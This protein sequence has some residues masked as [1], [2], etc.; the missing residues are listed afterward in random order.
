ME[1]ERRFRN[2]ALHSEEGARASLLYRL[3]EAHAYG[4]ME[5]EWQASLL[6]AV[7]ET[8]QASPFLSF[9]EPP[10][11]ALSP[12]RTTLSLRLTIDGQPVTLRLRVSNARVLFEEPGEYSLFQ[13]SQA[14]EDGVYDLFIQLPAL[15]TAGEVPNRVLARALREVG[16]RVRGATAAE[17]H[18]KALTVD[19]RAE[20]LNRKFLQL[21]FL[22]PRLSNLDNAI[23]GLRRRLPVLGIPA[24][25]TA[26]DW[27][28][29]FFAWLKNPEGTPLFVKPEDLTT[30]VANG[31]F[32]GFAW[33][34]NPSGGLKERELNPAMALEK[35]GPLAEAMSR[36]RS[37]TG[38]PAWAETLT[39][40]HL[41]DKIAVLNLFSAFIGARRDL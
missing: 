23:L 21:G 4:V 3:A 32:A 15:S 31:G 27:R 1:E 17:A 2:L 9:Q 26:D 20:L 35:P 25:R 13:I 12:D 34:L 18:E 33:G 29:R 38:A 41:E 37:L 22:T 39:L 7:K 30:A 40:L 24:A 19:P 8:I 6:S 36:D 28:G 10:V 16:E 14:L 11:A 5:E